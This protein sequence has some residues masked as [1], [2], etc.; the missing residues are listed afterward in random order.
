MLTW[1]GMVWQ[2][3][4]ELGQVNTTPFLNDVKFVLRIWE[5]YSRGKGAKEFTNYDWPEN[6]LSLILTPPPLYIRTTSHQNSIVS[7]VT[8]KAQ[9][10]T[11]FCF[12]TLQ[13]SS[14]LSFKQTFVNL[15]QF[16]RV[17][18]SITAKI[19]PRWNDFFPVAGFFLL[20]FFCRLVARWLLQIQWVRWVS[21]QQVRSS[22]KTS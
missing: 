12:E 19:W 4:I 6:L 7:H 15:W 3:D 13:N 21:F 8:D 1:H 11:V 9:I 2:A 18:A 10:A 17:K 14:F 5:S 22:Q 16:S 20:L